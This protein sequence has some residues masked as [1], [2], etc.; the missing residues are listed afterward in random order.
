MAKFNDL[1]ILGTARYTELVVLFTESPTGGVTDSIQH[2]FMFD[3]EA[4]AV[5]FVDVINQARNVPQ[6]SFS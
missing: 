2:S 6:R 3:T 5:R 1:E 4:D